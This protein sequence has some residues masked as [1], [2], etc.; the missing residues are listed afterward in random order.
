MVLK[1]SQFINEAKKD[2]N[3]MVDLLMKMLK[4]KP[5]VELSGSTEKDAYTRAGMKKYF[6]EHGMSKDNLDDVLYTIANDK[7]FK[8]VKAKLKDFSAKNFKYNQTVPYYYIDLSAEEIKA[9]KERIESGSKEAA[10]PEIEK[11]EEVKKKAVAAKKER[12]ATKKP[13]APAKAKTAA[14]KTTERKT[15]AKPRAKKAS[16]PKTE[17]K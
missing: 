7:E 12:E 16:T 17:G 15:P 10:K 13:K 14:D 8:E 1:Y 3:S 2:K 4:D 6:E 9:V 5:K 11:R